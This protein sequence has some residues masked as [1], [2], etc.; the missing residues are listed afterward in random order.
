MTQKLG[1]GW[2]F[3]S[4]DDAA[5]EPPTHP[6]LVTWDALDESARD[7]RRRPVERLPEILVAGGW[8]IV[9][10]APTIVIAEPPP[11]A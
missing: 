3:G 8:R 1:Q 5:A 10:P 9:R 4:S 11:V 7:K 2:V 6:E